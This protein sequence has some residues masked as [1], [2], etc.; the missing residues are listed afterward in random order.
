MILDK[1]DFATDIPQLSTFCLTLNSLQPYFTSSPYTYE[2]L[3]GYTSH[4]FH[5]NIQANNVNE[6]GPTM[7]DWDGILPRSLANLGIY[8][9]QVSYS[10]YNKDVPDV[11]EQGIEF[12]KQ[13]IQ[14]GYPAIVWD[15][16]HPAFALI[17]GYDDE[18]EIFH[19]IDAKCEATI[20]FNRLGQG[21]DNSEFYVLIIDNIVDTTF[22]QW[23]KGAIH[24]LLHYGNQDNQDSWEFI[25]GLEAYDTWINAFEKGSIDKEGNAYNIQ[26][27]KHARET[28]VDF[29]EKISEELGPDST[30]KAIAVYQQIVKDYEA[31]AALFPDANSKDLNSDNKDNAIALLKQLKEREK[32][33]L[34]AMKEI[35]Q[36]LP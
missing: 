26:V 15:A 4:A 22:D 19:A 30:S 13:S 7:Y 33:G 32:Q 31:L 36:T 20:P 16:I 3:M 2:E 14:S 25:S 23:L 17:Y 35:L 24:L 27:I 34:D 21:E 6:W 11:L 29:L 28:A 18:K 12:I 8:T 9:T 10:D 1:P 5:I